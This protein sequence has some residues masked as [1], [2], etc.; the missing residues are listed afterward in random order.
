[1]VLRLRELISQEPTP[2]ETQA[3]EEP[4]PSCTLSCS[5]LAR[6]L[7][8]GVA[9]N[10]HPKDPTYYIA[11]SPH[12]PWPR[13]AAL[14]SRETVPL[15]W[16]TK[17]RRNSFANRCRCATKTPVHSLGGSS[18]PVISSP[19]RHH[20]TE[21]LTVFYPLLRR[22]RDFDYLGA[23]CTRRNRGRASSRDRSLVN[24]SL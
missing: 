16:E 22:N 10:L 9:V 3:S 18:T 5:P 17:L 20:R 15:S 7:S 14:S 6:T 8:T 23:R 24:H 21:R 11:P 2:M 13:L 1:M 19:A 12:T 4:H